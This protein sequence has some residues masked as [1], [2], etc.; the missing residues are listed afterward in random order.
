MSRFNKGFSIIPYADVTSDM[1]TA[2]IYSSKDHMIRQ[3]RG[4]D[5]NVI[6]IYNLDNASTFS[7]YKTYDYKKEYSQYL[8]SFE[9]SKGIPSSTV[10]FVEIKGDIKDATSSEIYDIEITTAGTGYSAGT[11]TATGGGGNSFKGTYTVNGSG[12]ITA[13]RILNMGTGYT[14]TP[15]IVISDSGDSN[16]VLTP[17]LRGEA[18]EGNTRVL[19]VSLKDNLTYASTLTIDKNSTATSTETTKALHLDLDHTGVTGDGHTI[20]NMGLD[21]DVNSNGATHHAN[22]TVNNKGISMLLQGGTSGTQ[23][24]IGIDL[25]TY[26]AD[27]NDGI[28][29]N[30]TDTHLKLVAGAD[31][32]DYAT[33][34]VA[35]TGDLTIAT[36][37]DGAT[38]SDF[39]LDAD[40]D[41]TLDAASGN[42]YVKDNG[43]NYTPGSDYEIATK[44][45]VDDNAGSVTVDSSLTDGSTNPVQNNAVF[46]GLATKLNLSGG[47]VTGAIHMDD[48]VKI[49][50]GDSGEYIKGDGT[51]LTI[52]SS[53]KINFKVASELVVEDDGGTAQPVVTIKQP[54][55]NYGSSG[56]LVFDTTRG[57]STAGQDG[58]DLGLIL[59]KGHND[60]GTPEDIFYAR[61]F[62]EIDDAT[63]G[64]E[65]GKLSLGVTTHDGDISNY[66][67]VLTGGSVA[68]EIDVTIGNGDD[69]LTIIKGKLA[70]GDSATSANIILDEDNMATDSNTAL[71]TQQSIKAYVDTNRRWSI[72]TGGYR[73]NNN[74]SSTYYFQY[75]PNGEIWSNTDSSPTSISVYDSYASMLIAP[76]DGKV[77]KI[78][79][80]GYANDTGATDPLKFYV[81]KGTPSAG[82][83][84]MSLTQIGVTGTIT[85]AA[86]RV[87]VENVDITSSNT[88]SQHDAIFI[89]YKKDSTSGNQDLYFSIT[90]SG[91]YTS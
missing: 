36:V 69:S 43:G 22:G 67:L 29:I 30:C 10:D 84:S 52:E 73:S 45:Y 76:Y 3:V 31:S 24:N 16:A 66:G 4:E 13:L 53:G 81:F 83:T 49:E 14:S 46:D 12:A 6:V 91:E 54:A 38:D 80:H 17:R 47:T 79:V 86:L 28:H 61:I 25:R 65:S 70:F 48:D 64:Q 19:D 9:F 5:D 57:A 60:A 62:A 8:D 58:D 21:L 56:Q 59:F 44:K 40:G 68:D 23:T 72:E 71:A 15:T 20:T 75:R 89:M 87:F 34:S 32:D 78:S 63:D 90:V 33:L 37:G 55:G 51:D 2:S 74:S 7:A 18:L 50:F 77:T 88:F 39:L 26:G 1:V 35:D 85:P 27:T 41:I 82:T 11:L 42:I